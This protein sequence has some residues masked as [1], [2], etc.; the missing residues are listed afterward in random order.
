[1]TVIALYLIRLSLRHIVT[2][3]KITKTFHFRLIT[4]IKYRSFMVSTFPNLPLVVLMP[5]QQTATTT[6]LKQLDWELQLLHQKAQKK[7]A[8]I[9]EQINR[10]GTTTPEEVAIIRS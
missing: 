10:S 9:G 3:K 5:L 1:M 2:R 7:W 4:K 6:N 8:V